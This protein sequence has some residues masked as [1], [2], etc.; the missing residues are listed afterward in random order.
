MSDQWIEK[1]VKVNNIISPFEKTQI[2]EGKICQG[3]E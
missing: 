1:Q 2:R 3:L